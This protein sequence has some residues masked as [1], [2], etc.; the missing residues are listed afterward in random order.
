MITKDQLLSYLKK[1]RESWLSGES[2][3]RE[4][5][6]SR[7]AIWKHIRKLREEG[8]IIESSPK[9]GY[10]LSKNSDLLLPNEIKDDLGTSVFGKKDIEYFK[11][12]DSTNIKAKDLA[13]GGAPEGTVIIAE[14]QVKG[15]GR[16]GR[17]WLSPEGEGIYASLI[18]RPAMAPSGAPKITLMTAVAIAEA[19]LSLVQIKITIKWPNDIM[20]RGKKLAGILTEISTDMDA[21]NYII[22]G[23]GLN[24]NTPSQDFTEELKDRATSIYIETGEPISRARLVRAYL[25][26]FEKYYEMFKA[27]NFT[28]IMNRWKQLSN[29]IGQKI[30]VD[31]I[32]KKHVGKVT[33]IDDEGVLILRDD[34]GGS[35]RIFSGDITPVSP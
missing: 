20:I 15:R 35:Q 8:Y 5:S 28:P 32:G 33:D 30:I 25:E 13:E 17:T 14:K 6:V 11:E 18:L 3:S 34:E 21:V 29:I 23:L 7:A 12:I 31:V 19:L 22:V 24:V 2:L 27:N 26:Y 9:K 10:L 1:G 16:K 4:L